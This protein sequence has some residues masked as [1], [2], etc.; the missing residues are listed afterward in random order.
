M[1]TVG[2]E[3]EANYQTMNQRTAR[4]VSEYHVL[5]NPTYFRTGENRPTRVKP[6]C[7]LTDRRGRFAETVVVSTDL[8][9]TA[10][11]VSLTAVHPEASDRPPLRITHQYIQSLSLSQYL[12]LFY[13]PRSGE[14]RT[15]KLKS[16]QLRTQSLIVLPLKPGVGQYIA[17]HA[18]LTAR[19]LFLAN[20]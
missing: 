7:Y 14:L 2:G 16:H 18:M 5:C 17:I 19:E 20:F 8:E 9:K 4:R 10:Q 3:K 11:P 6:R 15:Q 13:F 12:F 1:N